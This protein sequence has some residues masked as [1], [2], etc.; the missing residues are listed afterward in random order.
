VN[1]DTGRTPTPLLPSLPA[2]F[3]AT[4]EALHLL[5]ARVLGAARYA[6]VGRLGLV[7]EPGGFGTPEFD[8]RKLLVV[9]GLLTDGDRRQ[10]LT[11]LRA[12]CAFAGVDP[13]DD[14]SPVQLW[15][16]RF[17]LAFE[18]GR[19]RGAGQLRGLSRRRRRHRLILR[20]G[21]VTSAPRV[22]TPPQ[23]PTPR[24]VTTSVPSADSLSLRLRP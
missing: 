18:K 17:D 7:V 23:H 2:G 16:G 9:D 4:R 8:G 13:A 5:G 24:A 3:T 20:S 21:T 19:P 15:P 12:A 11:T 6:A 22:T 1:D 10:P 14:P